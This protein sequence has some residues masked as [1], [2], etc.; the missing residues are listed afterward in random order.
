MRNT[1]INYI[2]AMVIMTVVLLGALGYF[3]YVPGL[4]Q[5]FGMSADNSILL[6]M[7]APIM[8]PLVGL[9]VW[10]LADKIDRKRW[11][12]RERKRFK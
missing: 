11:Y 8:V 3:L 1:L 2:I 7:T 6:V 9:P 5:Y 4:L 10:V 12:W